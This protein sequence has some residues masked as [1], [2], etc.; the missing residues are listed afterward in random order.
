MLQTS[1]RLSREN[2]QNSGIRY[3]AAADLNP[4]DEAAITSGNA[5]VLMK[6]PESFA[7]GLREYCTGPESHLFSNELMFNDWVKWA[8]PGVVADLAKAAD[9]ARVEVLLFIRNPISHAASVWQQGIKRSGRTA[10]IEDVF[11]NYR[12][13]SLVARL[14][15]RLEGIEN[16]T[17]TIKNY[18]A[19]RAT[20]LPEVS[21]WLQIPETALIKPKTATIN[22]SLTR[23]ELELQLAFNRV[24]GKSGDMLS[25]PLCEQLP[26]IKADKVL[27]SLDVQ[28][29]LWDNMRKDRRVVNTF[30]GPTHGYAFDSGEPCTLDDNIS[31]SREQIRVMVESVALR[32]KRNAGKAS[33]NKGSAT[34]DE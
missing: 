3:P 1:F 9:F 23:G 12:V 34:S 5:G 21:Q 32:L 6:N 19:C 29:A 18:N 28:K 15:R 30:A 10:S 16:L 2:L 31:L 22:R 20:L 14:I 26:E 4:A 17:L 13:P 11:A 7:A 24:F 33:A 27:P 8:E 25:D